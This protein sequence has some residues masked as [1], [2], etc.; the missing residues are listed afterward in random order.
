LVFQQKSIPLTTY[1]GELES[2][3]VA[4]KVEP[5]PLMLPLFSWRQFVGNKG[6]C[7]PIM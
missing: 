1:T 5:P 6:L 7:E 3:E 4:R 2:E